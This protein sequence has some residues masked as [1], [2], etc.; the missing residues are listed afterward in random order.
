MKVLLDAAARTRHVRS[1]APVRFWVTEFSWDTNPPDP[2]GVP[3]KLQARWLSEALGLR[4]THSELE[5][6][7]REVITLGERR[8][9]IGD[10]DLRRIVERLRMASEPSAAAAGHHVEAFGYGHGV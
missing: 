3:V 10:G 5:H 1:R 9:A 8:K 6:I 2:R 4:V 7:Y